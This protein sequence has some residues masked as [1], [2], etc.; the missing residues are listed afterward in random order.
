M[1]AT[2]VMIGCVC[3]SQ[4]RDHLAGVDVFAFARPRSPRRTAACSARARD[5]ASSAI[6]ISPE[7]ETATSSPPLALHRLQVV[8]AN[9]AAGLTWMLSIAVARDAAPPMWNVRI[10]SCVPGS[11]IDCAAMTPTASPTLTRWP[12]AR[13]R[14]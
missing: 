7:R 9:R 1:P 10:V 4:L 8:Q 14:P 2:S 13:S 3:G 11:P 5:R 12:R 6:A